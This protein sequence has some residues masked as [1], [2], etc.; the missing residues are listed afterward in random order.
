MLTGVTS[1]LL[2]IAVCA[3]CIGWAINRRRREAKTLA[4]ISPSVV[5]TVGILARFAF[6]SLIMGLTPEE[7][8]LDGEHR[9]YMVSWLYNKDTAMMWSVYLIA[10]G[11]GFG[12]L[13]KYVF[14][15]QLSNL[16]RRSVGGW[17][18]WMR[19]AKYEREDKYDGLV[20]LTPSILFLC[21][22]SSCISAWTGSMD[23]G[24]SYDYWAEMAFRP[25]A[26]FI[27]FARLKQIGYFLLPITW[28]RSSGLLRVFLVIVA[29]IPLI[30]ES[31]AGGRGSVLYP[32]VMVYIGYLCIGLKTRRVL[33]Y[34]ALLVTLL[35]VAVPYMAAYRDGITMVGKNHRDI[36]GRLSAYLTGVQ[37]D[38]VVYRYMALGRE[39]YACS[40]GFVVSASE[41]QGMIKA[42]ISDLSLKEIFKILLPRWVAKDQ[43]YEKGDGAS[44]AKRLMGVEKRN[45]FPCITTPADLFRREGWTGVMAGGAFMGALMWI[46]DRAWIEVG[47]RCRS[48]DTLLMTV[49]PVT[50]VQAGLY[51]TVRELIWQLMWD[52]P[53]YIIL[54]WGL[55]RAMRCIG[56][57]SRMVRR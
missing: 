12:I 56:A 31:V 54:F 44:I 9:Q 38:R 21:F 2:L 15:R 3:G 11:T 16:G 22:I 51:G 36:K 49:L 13:E 35:I 41:R 48:L 37:S 1:S 24:E 8:V 19:E 20:W 43:T 57:I 23:R 34:G 29:T 53:K 30:L 47:S 4:I 17:F 50:Y 5:F 25:E 6:G 39:L 52:L 46:L 27:A 14:A 42:G 32:I 55:A 45:W 28:K 10:G 33:I 18:E 7:L 26:V 40:D